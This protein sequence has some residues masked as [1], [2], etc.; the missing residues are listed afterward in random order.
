[1]DIKTF[2]DSLAQDEP[3]SGLPPA[4]EALWWDAR[5]EWDKAH[6]RAQGEGGA[7][8]AWVHAYLHR[9]EGDLGNVG[10]PPRA[11]GT[12]RPAACPLRALRSRPS[13]RRSCG[14]CSQGLTHSNILRGRFKRKLLGENTLEEN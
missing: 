6:E 9:K 14:I 3:P 10:L 5:G 2:K 7:A 13:G 12:A 11:T 4:L 1:M 8:G